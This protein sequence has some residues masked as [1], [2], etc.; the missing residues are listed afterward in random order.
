MRIDPAGYPFIGVAAL[1][2]IGLAL[3]GHRLWAIVPLVFVAFFL[4][5]FRDP[6]RS[7][8]LGPD[9]VV[10]PAD[11]KVMVAGEPEPGV[12]PPGP[13]RQLS[14]FLSPLDVH[15]N[16]IPVTGEVTKVEYRPGRFLPAYHDQ[17]ARDNERNEVW[18]DRGGQ[19]I[20][21]RQVVGILARRIVCRVDRGAHVSAGQ[22]FGVMKF[23]SRVDLYLPPGTTFRVK[24]GDQ[25]RS[26]E[27]VLAVLP[28][29]PHKEQR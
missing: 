28:P 1:I 2:A 18:I 6:D 14:I 12:A 22:R 23:G 16:R 20:V 3:F 5:F 9:D 27:T 8:I 7:A 11:G 29:A 21:T 4:F 13:W 19:V 25:V 15:V 26:G 24:P 17:A 10:S